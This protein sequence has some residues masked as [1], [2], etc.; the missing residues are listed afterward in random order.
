VKTNL[1][2]NTNWTNQLFEKARNES[3]YGVLEAS[4][5]E[6]R[7]WGFEIP[8][9]ALPA[10]HAL[11]ALATDEI[12]EIQ[13]E[14]PFDGLKDEEGL[15]ARGFEILPDP[16]QITTCGTISIG[17]D[18]TSGAITHLDHLIP[19]AHLSATR[20]LSSTSSIAWAS[21]TRPLFRFVYRTYSADEFTIF[22]NNYANQTAPPDW[23]RR[24]FGKPDMTGSTNATWYAR[25]TSEIWMHADADAGATT[26][27]LRSAIVDERGSVERPHTQYG[28][29]AYF[30][31]QLVVRH[32]EIAGSTVDSVLPPP[33]VE[34][35]IWSADKTPT[36]LPESFF[37]AFTPEGDGTWEM[38][39]LG[40][41]QKTE[42]DVVAGGSKHLHGVSIGSGIRF[43]RAAIAD[44][45]PPPRLSIE[46]VDAPVIN[47]GEPLG[48][49]VPCT[50]MPDPWAA[51][52]DVGQHG[53]SSMLWN[54]LWG[55]NYVMWYPFHRENV[56]VAG[57]EN[58][59]SR[60]NLRF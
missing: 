33:R 15:R 50:T 16:S 29:P 57:E 25:R 9:A 31:T 34:A 1:A 6:Q 19:S 48:F 42:R 43:T 58:F 41:W 18:A 37:V 20:G 21:A 51:E 59:I 2:D 14:V 7:Q 4:W 46:L 8:L 35:T 52:P 24:D 27:L 39:K 55:T 60:Y 54:N 12:G 38:Q 30:V 5:W 53:V 10:D 3:G 45:Q 11:H 32:E 49:P 40:Q 23:F 56:P 36:R 17:F 47:L 28:A 13:Q 44:W 26:F 22:Q